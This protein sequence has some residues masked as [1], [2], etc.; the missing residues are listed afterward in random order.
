MERIKK[1]KVTKFGWYVIKGYISY[2]RAVYGGIRDLYDVALALGVS[3][4]GNGTKGSVCVAF[5]VPFV[6]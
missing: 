3:V 5:A 6:L 2:S 1:I 4:G